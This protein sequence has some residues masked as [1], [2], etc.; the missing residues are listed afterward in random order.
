MVEARTQSAYDGAALVYG[1]NQALAY[2]GA[3]DPPSHA[4]VSTFTM[5]GTTINFFSHYAAPSEEGKLC[6]HQYLVAVTNLVSS[7][8]D[9]ERG[10]RQLR[11]V[12]E[13][14]KNESYALRDRLVDH[15][16]KKQESGYSASH[17]R[18][19]RPPPSD[20]GPSSSVKKRR[21]VE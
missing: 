20:D 18:K 2:M 5:D 8:E 9:F 21:R 6:Y 7:Y 11:N 14:A 12:Q 16:K 13:D 15:W 10:R 17:S 1:R 4:A 19:S 3:P